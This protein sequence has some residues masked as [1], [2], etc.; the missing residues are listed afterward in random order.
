MPLNLDPQWV[1]ISDLTEGSLYYGPRT[2]SLPPGIIILSFSSEAERFFNSNEHYVAENAAMRTWRE[3]KWPVLFPG[4]APEEDDLIASAFFWLSGWQE[5]VIEQR[6]IHARFSFYNSLQ[7]TLKVAT[8]PVVDA[9]REKLSRSLK[10]CGKTVRPRKWGGA[11]WALCPTIDVDYIV[12][13][14][15]GMIFRE[16]IEYL[17]LN[18]R[19][20]SFGSRINRFGEFLRDFLRRGD[21]YQHA[22]ERIHETISPN[23][24]ATF[25][26]KAAA[27]GPRDVHYS[28]KHPFLQLFVE[29]LKKSN[30]EIGLHP[31]F[32]AHN[33]PEYLTA[34][35]D[36]ITNLSG[37][38]PTSIRQHFLRYEAPT[39]PR[40]QQQLGFKIDSTLGFA[41]HEGFRNGTCL[42]FLRFDN[43]A[44]KATSVWEMPLIMMESALF[45]RRK[46]NLNE[47]LNQAIRIIR[48]CRRFGGVA[49]FLWHTVLWDEMDHPGWGEHFTKTYE[50]AI[51]N[52]AQIASLSTAL[53]SW[54]G[55]SE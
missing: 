51:E 26:F 53:N 24:T 11:Q 1:D 4:N 6:D 23:G 33:H 38:K 50:H 19:S 54:L 52:N 45:S 55:C 17:F 21:V 29:K 16:T 47:A 31:S 36:A 27:R 28:L 37:Y 18:Y 8:M 7:H 32:H 14:R 35:R 13:W 30:F 41:E 40:L 12:K 22:M 25:F 39:T 44:N 5:Y 15:K 3:E 9:Y 34:E 49:V 10:K 42:P 48:Q 2:K 43:H 20:E 46:L